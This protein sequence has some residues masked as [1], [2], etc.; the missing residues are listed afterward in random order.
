MIDPRATLNEPPVIDGGVLGE[1]HLR[2]MIKS[3]V[4]RLC[5]WTPVCLDNDAFRASGL[6]VFT[7]KANNPTPNPPRDIGPPLAGNVVFALRTGLSDS[8]HMDPFK[9]NEVS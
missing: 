4:W 5:E 8:R 6:R 2:K 1:A 9:E 3:K 7:D